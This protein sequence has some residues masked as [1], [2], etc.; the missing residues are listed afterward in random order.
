MFLLIQFKLY[1]IDEARFPSISPP[2]LQ[3]RLENGT[4]DSEEIRT[5]DRLNSA[6]INTDEINEQFNF[7]LT[8]NHFPS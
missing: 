4:V 3:R 7:G 1:T 8:Y 5:H 6:S 2:F